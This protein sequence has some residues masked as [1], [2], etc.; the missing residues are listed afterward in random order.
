MDYRKKVELEIGAARE[1]EVYQSHNIFILNLV[2]FFQ[3]EVKNTRG[4]RE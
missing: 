1:M 2:Y 4:T 3:D